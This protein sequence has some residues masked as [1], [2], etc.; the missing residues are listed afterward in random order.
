MR[1]PKTSNGCAGYWRAV[2]SRRRFLKGIF[3]AIVRLL[4]AEFPER[5]EMPERF[6]PFL[7][8]LEAERWSLGGANTQ[9]LALIE[10]VD[11]QL[12]GCP[13]PGV[14][15]AARL[16]ASGWIDERFGIA[17]A[18]A[19]VVDWFTDPARFSSEWIATV[20]EFVAELG[21]ATRPPC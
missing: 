19:A 5:V 10:L 9:L 11:R 18:L 17:G 16:I 2:G 15:L 12:R 14:E 3:R 20:C 8:N 21:Q 6:L 13:G 7:S 1:P 4:T